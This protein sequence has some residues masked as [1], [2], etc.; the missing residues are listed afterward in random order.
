VHH[1]VHALF[2]ERAFLVEG[3]DL[4][5]FGKVVAAADGAQT[6]QQIGQIGDAAGLRICCSCSMSTVSSSS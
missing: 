5:Q 1:E 4:L 3:L 2:V 6:L